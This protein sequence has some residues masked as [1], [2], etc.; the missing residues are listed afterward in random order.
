M[1]LT[2]WV[3]GRVSPALMWL[4][5]WLYALGVGSLYDQEKFIGVYD[6]PPAFLCG[7]LAAWI[8]W[9]LHKRL[10]EKANSRA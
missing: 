4:A 5:A 9:N 10:E 2:D 1:R 6:V 7:I 8:V 3:G